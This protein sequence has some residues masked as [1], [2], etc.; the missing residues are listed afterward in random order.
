MS[1]YDKYYPLGLGTARFPISN[2]NDETGIEESVKLVL[3]ALEHGVNYIDTSYIYSAGMAQTVL[4]HAFAQTNRSYGVTLKVQ[5]G[6]DKTAD[7]AFKRV[8]LQLGMMGIERAAFFVVWTIMSYDEFEKITQ[9]GGIYDGA[10]KLKDEGI[11]DHIC[12]STHAAPADIVRIIESDA[13]E[14]VTISYSPI[15]STSMQPVLN[16]ALKH[17]IGVVVMNPLGGGLIPQN[18]NYFSFLRNESDKST[19]HAALRYEAAQPAINIILSGC[20][21]QEQL[22]DSLRAFSDENTEPDYKRV[23][24]V[25]VKLK[26]ALPAFCTG[27]RYCADNCPKSI[28][29]PE[30]MQSYNMLQF[31]PSRLYNHEDPE[32][33][34]NIHLFRRLVFDFGIL[35]EN[36][37]NP[38]V[39]CG[40]CEM[41]CT[42]KLSICDALDDIYS[43]IEL[44]G[45][46][47][48]AKKARLSEIFDGKNY[49][50]VG[51]YPSG[52]YS[53][54]VLNFYR[55]F[56]GEPEFEILMFNSSPHLRGSMVGEYIIHSP[57]EI[58]ELVPDAILVTS[59]QHGAAI[60][61]SIK[62]YS[63]YGIDLLNLHKTNDVPWVW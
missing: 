26:S 14:G 28:Q 39:R 9:K 61:D 13:F 32:L 37:E 31:E 20:A 48:D 47:K 54:A 10:L 49:N 2:P 16:A 15:N 22:K 58:A 12:F 23:E 7:D 52:G 50:K 24:R 46:S 27:C 59:Y 35:P 41:K 57:Y 51:F 21:S 1:I 25:N 43:R 40:Q 4:R 60:F 18:S 38:C 17:N 63:D 45:C 8:E 42:Q 3:C 11:V 56:F 29:I 36:S 6:Q 19:V 53:N 44:T 55:E 30:F 62:Q 34:K 33:L 5:Y